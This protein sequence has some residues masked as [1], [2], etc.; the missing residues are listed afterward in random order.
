[1]TFNGNPKRR[2]PWWRCMTAAEK[3]KQRSNRNSEERGWRSNM[4]CVCVQGESQ[5]QTNRGLLAPR[6]KQMH[7]WDWVCVCGQS[8]TTNFLPVNTVGHRVM[9]D[10]IGWKDW[11]NILYSLYLGLVVHFVIL[12]FL[13][14]V[15]LLW[16]TTDNAKDLIKHLKQAKSTQLQICKSRIRCGHMIPILFLSLIFHFFPAILAD[17]YHF[18]ERSQVNYFWL[19]TGHPHIWTKELCLFQSFQVNVSKNRL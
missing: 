7:L 15:W 19:A 18:M 16:K 3:G 6:F 1:M 2:K 4:K 12:L 9:P 13:P 8:C 10:A 17:S 14:R 11:E 5:L